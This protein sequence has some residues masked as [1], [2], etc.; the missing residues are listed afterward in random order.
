MMAAQEQSKLLDE[1][2]RALAED[3]ETKLGE[4]FTEIADGFQTRVES[5]IERHGQTAVGERM[6]RYPISMPGGTLFAIFRPM[7]SEGNIVE[8]TW[9][10]DEEL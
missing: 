5:L 3:Y 8:E 4:A 6:K 7:V 1:Q 9:E 2:V 10:V